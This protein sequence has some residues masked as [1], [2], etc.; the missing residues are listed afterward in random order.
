MP[1][2]KHT[3]GPWWVEITTPTGEPLSYYSEVSGNKWGA[4]AQVV[5]AM[6]GEGGLCAEGVANARLIAAAPE[7]LEA[8]IETRT[9]LMIVAEQVLDASKTDP[10]W[11][12]VYEKLTPYLEQSRAAI[13]K[14]T[15]EA[16]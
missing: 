4:L 6:D 10:R 1:K 2:P 7:L 5:T 8:L 13:A 11:E 16:S 3:P 15:G 12:G 9:S 14:A